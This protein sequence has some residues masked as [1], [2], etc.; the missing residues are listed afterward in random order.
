MQW[1]TSVRATGPIWF[2]ATV[3]G[4][5]CLLVAACGTHR[6]DNKALTTPV[7]LIEGNAVE[8]DG[9]I[10]E[11]EDGAISLLTSM[12]GDL[13]GDAASD[14]AAILVNNSRGS[15]VF[16]YL[17][18]LLNDG[19]GV[20]EPAGEAFLGDRIKLDIM[21]IYEAGFNSRLADI[22]I[23]PDDHRLLVVGYY[24]HGPDQAYSEDP[25]IY[26]TRR[27]WIND[28]KLVLVDEY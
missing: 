26:V 4:T 27:W 23:H 28:R 25:G 7:Y 9:G 12:S 18:V 21:E 3:I 16:Y 17:N 10:L 22:P 19:N 2:G 15:G 14:Q 24:L 8:L 6:L 11:S 5:A 1:K 13:D 20:L